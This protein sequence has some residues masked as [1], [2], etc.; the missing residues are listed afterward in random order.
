MRKSSQSGEI[1]HTFFTQTLST[2]YW[3]QT[4]ND[5]A[6]QRTLTT[7]EKRTFQTAM[8]RLAGPWDALLAKRETGCGACKDGCAV[9]QGEA[10]RNPS[11]NGDQF[12][13]QFGQLQKALLE[14]VHR[15]QAACAGM[16]PP[17]EDMLQP[18][19]YADFSRR[20]SGLLGTRFNPRDPT[21][22]LKENI[23][24]PAYSPAL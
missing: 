10:C 4:A 22:S 7:E 14:G 12:Q 6:A 9:G 24:I 23:K 19:T 17:L 13:V 21:H 3:D 8:R 18:M 2:T 5:I 11:P 1:T 20:A 15:V 16:Q